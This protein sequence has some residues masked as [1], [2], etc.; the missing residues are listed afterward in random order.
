MSILFLISF[1]VMNINVKAVFNV[2]QTVLPNI[3]NGGSIVNLS[4]LAGLRAFHDHSVYSSSKAAV[5]ALTR[6]LTLELGPRGIRVNS[7]N[8]TAIL[9][10]MGRSV[11]GDKAKAEGLLNRIPLNRFG[12]VKEVTD[13]I[14]FLLSD[15]SSFVNGHYL[16]LEGGFSAC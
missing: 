16:R 13:A 9:T 5:D 3:E 12:E 7:V 1:R 10:S 15:S 11:W 2:T 6:S 14:V 4:S 8:P